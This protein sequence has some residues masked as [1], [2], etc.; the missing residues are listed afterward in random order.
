MTIAV[1]KTVNPNLVKLIIRPLT[2]TDGQ[3]VPLDWLNFITQL[4]SVT[5]RYQ[6]GSFT[7]GTTGLSGA[8]GTIEYRICGNLCFI[9]I[10][11]SITGASSSTGFTITGFPSLIQPLNSPTIKSIVCEDNTAFTSTTTASFS[12]GT[13]TLGNT[14]S[15]GTAGWSAVGTKGISAQTF[16]YPLT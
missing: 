9:T 6:E 3:I 11:T 12:G 7:C 4:A 15:G 16:C 2:I 1:G 10:P 13:L 8:T 14:L 5:P